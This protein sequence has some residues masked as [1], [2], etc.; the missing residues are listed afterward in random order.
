MD[1]R[2]RLRNTRA[3]QCLDQPAA[4]GGALLSGDVPVPGATTQIIDPTYEFHNSG[5]TANY[6][7]INMD[8]LA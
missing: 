1:K 7:N 2:R 4:S 8:S 5:V 6:G 3:S